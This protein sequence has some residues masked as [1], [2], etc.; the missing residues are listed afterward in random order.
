MAEVP[1]SPS[2]QHESWTLRMARVIVKYRVTVA[3]LLVLFTSF[4]GYP[5][6]NT[7]SSAMG[8]PLPGPMV[9]I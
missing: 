1:G 6:L 5:I 8:M 3:V 4:F 7:I 2:P 9:R